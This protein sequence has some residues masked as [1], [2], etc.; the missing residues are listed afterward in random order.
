MHIPWDDVGV[1]LAVAETGSLSA[2]AKRLRVTQPTVSRRVAEL[3]ALVGEALFARTAAGASLTS[4]SESLVEPARRMAEW[5]AEVERAAERAETTPRGEVRITAPPGIAFDFVAPFAA[6]A[7]ARLPEVRFTV[8]SSTE[9]LDLSRGGA[10]LALR[11]AAPAQR[12][13]VTLAS[14]DVDVAAFGSEAYART[15]PRRAAPRDVAWIGWAPPFDDL[16]PNPELA[17]MIPSFAPAFASDDYLVQ[18]RAA[19]EGLG[20][21]FLGL[22]RHR[23]W[24]SRLVQLDVA[25][26][27]MRRALHLA[28]AR[29]ALEI[30][31]IRAVADLLVAELESA[32]PKPAAGARKRAGG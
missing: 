21:M 20:A 29:R 31:R 19:E 13:V 22:A 6:W 5:A 23:F 7:K 30:P 17:R 24:R 26:P 11:F 16:S 3:E 4:F 1:F 32:K 12:D 2:A 18:L 10:D 27:P 15:L 28:C 14:L 8:L 9:Y 25:L